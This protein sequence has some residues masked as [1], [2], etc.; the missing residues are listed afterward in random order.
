MPSH[1]C[2]LNPVYYLIDTIQN[3]T[4]MVLSNLKGIQVNQ[5]HYFSAS[6]SYNQTPHDKI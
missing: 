1:V 6:A 3:M 4:V 2:H 5:I